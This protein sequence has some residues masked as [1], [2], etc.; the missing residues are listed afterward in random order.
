MTLPRFALAFASAAI[1]GGC[2]HTGMMRCA[3]GSRPMVQE[4]IYFGTQR[5]DG[6]V[7]PAEWASFVDDVVA[8]AFPDGF[9]TWDAA[10]GWRGADGRALREASHVV[11]VVHAADTTADAAIARTIADYEAR[12]DQEA[13]MRA[14][15][16]ACVSF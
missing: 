2:A 7:S 3:A 4:R 12:F 1:L 9:T 13:V 16:P 6:T 8:P 11:E 15:A 10:G 14:S 5:P